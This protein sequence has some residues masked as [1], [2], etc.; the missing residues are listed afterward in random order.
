MTFGLASPDAL[1]LALGRVS[2]QSALGEPLRAEIELPEI[3]PEEVSSL[4]ASI[5]SPAQFRAAGVEFSP[6]LSNVQI[7]LQRRPN[8]SF[9]LQLT[10]DRPVNDPFVD[11]ILEA[12]WATGR[13]QRDFTLLLDPPTLRQQAPLQAQTAPSTQPVPARPA[14]TPGA[15]PAP[16]PRSTAPGPRSPAR[17]AAAP[18]PSG[19]G[20]RVT[21]RPGD[22][23]GKL[24]SAAK[25]AS[26]SL[27]QMLV[28]MLRTNP[29][30]FVAGNVNRLRAGAVLD[31][32]SG[33]QA[34]AVPQEEAHQT[35]VAQSRDFNEFRRRLAE[36][37][38]TAAAPAAGRAASGR[39]QAEVEDKKAPAGPGDRLTLSKGAVQGRSANAD[40]IARERQSRDQAT[41]VAELN[42]NLSE[43]NKLAGS[44]PGSAGGTGARPAA[45]IA[46]PPGVTAPQRGASAPAAS[47]GPVV[48]TARPASAPAAATTPATAARPASAPVAT[49]RP[50]AAPTAA[51]PAP[52]PAAATAARPASAPATTAPAATAARPAPSAPAPA[53]ATATPTPAPAPA[54]VPAATTATTAAAPT[55]PAPAAATA[56]SP[57]ATASAPAATAA[58]AAAA[59]T[60]PAASG[61]AAAAK[62]PVRKPAPPPPPEP[63][64]VD[65]LLENP[66]VPAL[67]VGLLAVLA[68]FGFYKF[69]Q[70]RKTAAVDSSFLESRLQPDSFFGASGGQRIDTA[71][72]NN[73]TGS[74]MVYSPSQLD[75][76]G[77]VDP[78]AEADVYLAYGRD[79]QAEEILK[80][81]LR[82]NPQRV[83]IHAKLLEIYAKRRDIK[84]FETVAAEA[85]NLTGGNGPEWEHI[86]DLGRELDATNPLYRPGG[87]PGAGMAAAA[88][89]AVAAQAFT[90]THPSGAQAAPAPDVDLDLDFSLG[91]EPDTLQP[92]SAAPLM[93]P[94][95][96]PEPVAAPVV[97]RAEPEPLNMNFSA[98]AP[99]AV[100]APEP[101]RM[102]APPVIEDNSL[103]FTPP[104]PIMPPPVAQAPATV[105]DS[106]MLEF[107]LGGLN[108]DLP[109]AQAPAPAA[110]TPVPPP[111][112]D[113]DM[114]PLAF[115]L[116]QPSTQG[117]DLSAPAGGDADSPLATKLAL[118]EEFNAIGDADGARSLA[119]EVLAEA[120]G[121]LKSRAQRLL[122]EIG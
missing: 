95:G 80:E 11:V 57:A 42:K 19:E 72:A 6:A 92:T 4:K 96:R 60:A 30:A 52:A 84:A 24:A 8:G 54:P 77:D 16:T 100:L 61:A 13:V 45:G 18:A 81:A 21:V 70:K 28:A 120:S 35:L 98:P 94:P 25:P 41:R 93:P 122:A 105:P 85:Y 97:A 88:A 108:L 9:F 7:T 43:L 31:M 89:G 102:E 66:L 86:C 78:V 14:A 12:T 99:A 49:T 38:P 107:D 47:T 2:V 33:E 73:P 3:T 27:D 10:N 63:S 36:G 82:I 103:D 104:P 112:A 5:A 46:A 114:P 48:G 117:P 40:R 67:V 29:D 1:A 55:T 32:P 58:S 106:G 113:I 71:E 44:T 23:A 20:K 68:G 121:D 53:A 37:V 26:V 17:A 91:D 74:S 119:E 83:A 75:A 101:V 65:D 118:A 64:L 39:V 115:D 15:I 69:R 87:Q 51:T 90:S 34:A 116:D 59:G 76:A 110:V 50:A 22:T 111:P 109:A 79:L 56:S 62:P